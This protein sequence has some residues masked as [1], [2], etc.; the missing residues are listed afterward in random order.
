MRVV[1]VVAALAVGM[2]CA[3]RVTEASTP[4]AETCTPADTI[5]CAVQCDEGITSACQ[6]LTRWAPALLDE[7]GHVPREA[8]QTA[9]T[10]GHAKACAREALHLL[11]AGHAAAAYDLLEPVCNDREWYACDVA[12]EVADAVPLPSRDHFKPRKVAE[13][14]SS[15]M[16]SSAGKTIAYPRVAFE[17]GAVGSALLLVGVRRDGQVV[18]VRVVESAGAVLDRAARFGVRRLVWAPAIDKSGAP[19]DG[20]ARYRVRFVQ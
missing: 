8:L 2:G 5:S 11:N 15:P 13:L 7:Q 16:P 19:V 3:H 14:L 12:A 20:L 10:N 9:C 18:G 1:V 17:A 4:G 6:R